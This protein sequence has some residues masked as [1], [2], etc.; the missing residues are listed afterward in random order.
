[1]ALAL[2]A[3]Q[4]I[5]FTSCS[6]GTRL[7]GGV[8]QGDSLEVLL[9]SDSV[10]RNRRTDNVDVGAAARPTDTIVARHAVGVTDVV[11]DEGAN[12]FADSLG[13]AAEGV[14]AAVGADLDTTALQSPLA[15]AASDRL[16]DLSPESVERIDRLS[17]S[18]PKVNR[19]QSQLDSMLSI[20]HPDSIA[21]ASER[22]SLRMPD[23]TRRV[24]NFL[25]QKIEGK[26]Q[27]SLVF[28]VRTKTVHI[29]EK[30]DVNYGTMNMK[31]DYMRMT[32]ED[33]QLYAYGRADTLLKTTTRPE[34][35][36][37]GQTYTMD[38][39]MYNIGSKK[40]LIQNVNTKDG[41]GFLIGDQVKMMA[42]KSINLHGGMYTTCDNTEHPHFAIRMRRAKVIPN[43]KIIS[44]ICYL[45]VEDVPIYFPFVPEFMFP[46]NRERK[47]G[48]IMPSY[49]EESTKGF[50]LRDLGYY[51]ALG[52]YFDL[53]L[54]GGIYT[55]GSWEA[56]AESKYV[57]RYKY[58]GNFTF[59]YSKDVIGEKGDPSY[60]DQGNFK[61]AWTHTQ[62]PKANP[63]R[64][65]SAS[66]NLSSSGYSKNSSTTLSEYLNSQTNSSISYSRTWRG[67]PFSLSAN[68]QHSQNSRDSTIALTLPSVVFNM[69]RVYPFKRKNL[70]GKERWYEKIAMTYNAKMSNTVQ[71]KE[72]LLLRKETL[73]EFKNGILHTIPVSTTMN[74]FGYINISP[75]FNYT[76]RW[77][78]R[79]IDKEWDPTNNRLINSDT[80]RG[81][82][83]VYN[84]S[85]SASATT[86]LYG[87]YRFKSKKSPVQA[88]RHTLTPSVSLSWAP[89]FSDPKYGFYKAVQSDESGKVSW[90]SPFANEMY[91]VP[92]TGRTGAVSFSLAQTLEMKVLSK[93]DTS[94]MKKLK[95]IDNL[96]F[97]GS[98]NMLADSMKLST[99]SLNLRSTIIP[100]FGIQLSAV[101]DPYE[102]DPVK[103]IRYDKL[104]WGRGLPGR[105]ASTGW[106]CGYTWNSTKSGK[107]AV[108]DI[109]S[110]Y[111]EYQNPFNFD[112]N[113]PIDPVLRR[114]MMTSTYY[115]FDIP[116]NFGFSYSIQYANTGFK[117]TITNTF[118]FNGSIT[119]TPKMGITF[120][121]GYDFNNK[122]LTPGT[123]TLSRDLH[124]WQMNFSCVPFGYR[125]SW[126]FNISVKSSLLQDLKY[127]K[128]SSFYDN[129]YE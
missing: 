11:G 31:A 126:S 33:K 84:Y 75:S 15:T 129:L 68:L 125:K 52:E 35:S 17:D 82:Y 71:T 92:G 78:F 89:N 38:T 122:T 42:D 60:T 100:K 88:I 124:C 59:R 18:L 117:K 79:K 47:N 104:M 39:V 63:N 23:G 76:E 29:Y 65:F 9:S 37:A 3:V 128:N 56:S 72:N 81:F 109:N 5:F 49:G 22:D 107:Q 6:V 91:G 106:S 116:W 96:S 87:M 74:L 30:G 54:L 97:S 66:V 32:M 12:G 43:E 16:S 44:G 127:E 21:V 111:P 67:T 24:R 57:K 119:L 1:M 77:Y 58:N 110:Q 27:D 46:M 25:D 73:G 8:S 62:D 85:L 2:I 34:F 45:E 95:V 7:R 120:N 51:I 114:Q 41:D 101:L 55:L 112:P 19:E 64:T 14:A 80:T 4:S 83:R 69:S 13:L 94:G 93:A 50:F 26:N 98:Y 61:V 53:K 48:F 108:N 113:S 20:T 10:R 36:D 99:I 90:Y 86:T 121:G 102:V 123:F 70:V 103:G 40:A 118:S 28:D 115:D 105:I